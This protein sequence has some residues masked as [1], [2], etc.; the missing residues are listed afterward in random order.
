MPRFSIIDCLQIPI[1]ILPYA[2]SVEA[3]E[4]WMPLWNTFEGIRNQPTCPSSAVDAPF[5]TLPLVRS[6]ITG[7]SLRYCYN[8][9]A[10]VAIMVVVTRAAPEKGPGRSGECRAVFIGGANTDR[11]ACEGGGC[12]RGMKLKLP[13]FYR[14]NGE[15]HY[16]TIK[17]SYRFSAKELLCL[18]CL[19]LDFLR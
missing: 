13:P 14:V 9:V 12:G 11:V 2:C 1:A 19:Q 6:V 4:L 5:L 8:A 10:M 3:G 15:V 17:H 18:T 7:M 16:N